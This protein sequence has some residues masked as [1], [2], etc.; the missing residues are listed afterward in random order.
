MNFEQSERYLYSLGNEVEAM[1]LG[2]EN[3]RALLAALGNPHENYFKVQVAGTNGKGSVCAFLDS[4]CRRAGIRVGLYTSPHLTSITERIR[5]DGTDISEDEFARLATR[6]RET[7]ERLL[8]E[9]K[10]G[11]TPTYFE[12]VTAIG[13]LAFAVAKVELAILETGLGGRLDA[14]TAANAEIAAITQIALDHQEYLGDTIEEIAAEKAAIIRPSSKVVLLHQAKNVERVLLGRCREV[15]VEPAWASTQIQIKRDP[16]V[17]PMLFGTI[18]TEKDVYANFDFWNML[19]EHQFQNASVAI[20]V[21]ELLRDGGYQIT[22]DEIC[23]GLETTS[24][25]GRLEYIDNFLLDGAHNVAG[26][27]A[28]ADYLDEFVDR[29]FTMIFGAMKDKD[30]QQIAEILWPRAA[31]LILTQPS[32]TRAFAAEE[33]IQFLPEQ[34]D[35]AKVVCATSDVEEAFRQA[36]QQEQSD[37]IIVVTG[38]LYLVG[39]V[40]K[41]ALSL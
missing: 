8:A 6:V 18:T 15:G 11:Y 24:H 3:I 36:R 16:E 29:P 31:Q 21:A 28:L 33:L 12:Q 19:G 7:A 25:A 38:S 22:Y 30:V 5:I 23:I 41:L 37:S 17:A 1:K 34:F 39:E 26:A 4:I 2:L 35:E 10:L 27:E 20:A 13:L 32:N 40:R 14:T 9:G